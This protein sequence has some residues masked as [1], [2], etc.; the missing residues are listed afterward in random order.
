MGELQPQQITP[1][2][3]E[4]INGKI[5]VVDDDPVVLNMTATTFRRMGHVVETATNGEELLRMLNNSGP[6]EFGLLISDNNMPEMDGIDAIK[7]IRK[8]DRFKNL[9]I[10]INSGLPISQDEISGLKI[11]VLG[12]PFMRKELLTAIKQ[13]LNYQVGV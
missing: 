10:V 4:G 8:Q 13:A 6:G 11:V 12:K 9:P 2:R 1:E 3:I 5:L 7:E